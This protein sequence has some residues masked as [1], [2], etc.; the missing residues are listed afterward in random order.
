MRA[1]LVCGFLIVF[2]IIMLTYLWSHHSVCTW[3]LAVSSFNIEIIIKVL[4]S[5]S[6][7]SLFLIDA[8]RTT[9]WE[10]LDDYVYYIK[11]FGNTVIIQ[12][13]KLIERYY[14]IFI[15]GGILFWYIFVSERCLY[16]G[17]CIWWCCP[18]IHDVYTCIF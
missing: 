13:F 8:Y 5:L 2:P 3:L 14:F 4:V 15:S 12:N 17:I 16:N 10:R 9:F 6:V 7:Y 11:A 18:C 1:L